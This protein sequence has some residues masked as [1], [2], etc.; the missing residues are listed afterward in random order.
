[1]NE[2]PYSELLHIMHGVAGAHETKAACIGTV[3]QAPPNLVI[4]YNNILLNSDELYISEYL[5]TDY[6]RTTKGH[7]KSATQDKGGGSG[8]ASFESHNHSIDNDYTE[9]IITTDTLKPGDKVAMLPV[10]PDG[11]RNLQYIIIDKIV[12]PDRRKF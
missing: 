12:R 5:L 3:K 11:S 2:N 6:A 8:D 4:S 7:L 9:S 1:M 10:L